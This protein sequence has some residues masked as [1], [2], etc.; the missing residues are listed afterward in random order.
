MKTSIFPIILAAFAGLLLPALHG[1]T[2]THQPPKPDAAQ[3]I[4]HL[5]SVVCAD[6]ISDIHFAKEERIREL[7][8]RRYYGM[9]FIVWYGTQEQPA[10]KVF[11]LDIRPQIR[12]FLGAA[13]KEHFAS[14]ID[15]DDP[16]RWTRVAADA[17]HD[18]IV[19]M[20]GG[21]PYYRWVLAQ[22]SDP[23]AYKEAV[24]RF[25]AVIASGKPNE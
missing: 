17:S 14:L 12:A 16:L 4:Q 8:A 1:Q 20:S 5:L 6:A 7:T 21:M 24:Q 13:D 15:Y 23:A 22:T 19:S 11:D 18:D 3:V 10:G 25:R 9:L 2:S